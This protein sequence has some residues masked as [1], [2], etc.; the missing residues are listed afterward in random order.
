MLDPRLSNLLQ[1][2]VSAFL[3][4][5]CNHAKRY[6]STI[7]EI[8]PWLYPLPRAVCKI[9]YTLCKIRGEKV[10]CQFMANEPKYLEPML[11]AFGAWKKP[12]EN[13]ADGPSFDYG[14]MVW[15]E[16]YIMLLWLSHLMLT[17]FDLSSISSTTIIEADEAAL[18]VSL[19]QN[20]PTIAKRVIALSLK[21]I[22]SASKEREAAHFL[23]VRLVLRPDMLALDLPSSLIRWALLSLDFQP[24]D[25]PPKTIYAHIGVLSFLSGVVTSARKETIG[26]FLGKIF[27]IVQRITSAQSQSSNMIN[28]SALARKSIIKILR[29]ITISTISFDPA[30][31]ISKFP[32]LPSDVLEE[33][34]EHLLNSLADKDTPVRYAASKALSVV[35]VRL[36]SA[37]AAE[38]V[39]AIVGSL[40]ENMLWEDISTGQVLANGAAQQSILGPLKRNVT[41]VD[42][43][44]WHGLILTLSHLLYRR[45]PPPEQLPSILNALILAL[46]FEQ[47]S[48]VGGSIGTNVR[49][50]ACFGIWAL[51]RR[52]NSE[53]LCMID[54]SM[55]E[56]ANSHEHLTTVLQALANEIIVA[57]TLDLSGNIRRGA[58][59]ALQELIGRHPDVIVEG[60][61]LVQV[62]DYHA[63]ALRSRAVQEV[64]IDAS[65]LDPLYWESILDGVLKWR[66]LGS[67]DAPTRRLSALAIGS[68]AVCRG[69]GNIPV[70]LAK[71]C[72]ILRRTPMRQVEERHGLLLALA[73]II[74]EALLEKKSLEVRAL[75]SI[76]AL[77]KLFDP[78][79]PLFKDGQALLGTKPD[80]IAEASCAFL[81]VLARFSGSN[82]TDMPQLSSP[83]PTSTEISRCTD[84]LNLCLNRAEDIVVTMSANAADN[85]FSLLNDSEREILVHEWVGI[86]GRDNSNKSRG[87]AKAFGVIAALGLVFHHFL[88]DDPDILT[89]IQQTVVNSLLSQTGPGVEIESRVAAIR[90]L[91]SGILRGNG[92]NKEACLQEFTN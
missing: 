9:L 56:A 24:S 35:V 62:V 84:I 7:R 33:V 22:G 63:V 60:I 89:E 16:R 25:A 55:V 6:R 2:L 8:S 44:R 42:A 3:A 86:L 48:S 49:D 67:P 46:R 50:A 90:S 12:F 17:P 47:R 4:Y 41:A 20:A 32:D 23:L 71:V 72:D 58:S 26:P 18:Q 83:Y 69:T 91:A 87:G 15:E 59:A 11:N 21:Y 40:E 43:L 1:I 5:M 45:S 34:I 52:Y 38:V 54:A 39:D 68:L 51:A 74:R 31:T 76:V 73:A 79:S 85:L 30:N 37:M 13:R 10:I 53:E 14:P 75:T 64:A 28:S 66:G 88:A 27:Q 29:A 57:A 80:L 81:S 77:W 19:P 78:Q 65:I 70:A 82:L 92:T 36:E 61:S